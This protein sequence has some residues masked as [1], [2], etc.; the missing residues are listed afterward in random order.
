MEKTS[1]PQ[2]KSKVKTQSL[3]FHQFSNLEKYHPYGLEGKYL[4]FYLAEKNRR[5]GF[6]IA[7]KDNPTVY[8]FIEM[9]KCWGPP[10]GGI[11]LTHTLKNLRGK[12]VCDL[13]TG[14][15]ALNAITASL[16]GAKQAMGIEINPK[17]ATWAKKIIADNELAN[18]GVIEGS[19][20][21]AINSEEK[22]DLILG[23]LS[24]S[25]TP[26]AIES[27]PKD[28]H[29][30][31]GPTGW[32]IIQP[33]LDQAPAYLTD[34]G[35]FRL[36]LHEFLGITRKFGRIPTAFERFKRAGLKPKIIGKKKIPITHHHSMLS[37]PELRKHLLRVYPRYLIK[38]YLNIF[39]VEGEKVR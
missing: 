22:F 8:L 11:F 37:N 13:G 28:W 20:L 35:S 5:K 7:K 6:I 21:S 32:E 19:S 34:G 39:V 15:Y 36:M 10:G 1:Q 25:P 9:P 33:Y 30:F 3:E 12:S 14:Y 29:D 24:M 4:N 38:D 17:A 16:L 31:A 27:K 26:R 23:N 2:K 18:V